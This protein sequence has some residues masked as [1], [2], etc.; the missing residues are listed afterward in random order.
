MSLNALSYSNVNL[1]SDVSLVMPESMKHQGLAY[2][3]LPNCKSRIVSVPCTNASSAR[4]GQNLIIALPNQGVYKKQSGYLKFRVKTI[5]AASTATFK[6]DAGVSA[7]FNRMTI[8]SGGVWE[9]LPNYDYWAGIIL[10]NLTNVN[11]IQK[12]AYLLEGTYGKAISTTDTEFCMPILSNILGNEKSLNLFLLSSPLQIELNLNSLNRALVAGGTAPTDF[13]VSDI[14]FV[15]ENIYAGADYENAVRAY[16]Q[17]NGAYSFNF[18]TYIGHQVSVA[19]NGSLSFN[20]GIGK[21]AVSAI[22][23]VNVLSGDLSASGAANLGMMIRGVN[24]TVASDIDDTDLGL[25]CFV[26]GQSV[27]PQPINRNAQLILES[28]RACN[29]CFDTLATIA[30]R[31][32]ANFGTNV[33]SGGCMV[34]GFNTRVFDEQNVVSG[35][36]VQNF[37]LVRTQAYGSATTVFIYCIYKANLRID[38]SGMTSIQS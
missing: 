31:T 24:A 32:E 1:G 11:Y 18:D 30:V 7:L 3:A 4:S 20:G 35:I 5:T 29:S 23:A 21:Q 14:R 6:N 12:D 37:Q 8:T 17:Q 16:V 2:P 26:D 10:S 36:P 38:A 13:E 22:L 9:V 28:Q 34:A 15:Y 25:S 27:L 19:A 33:L